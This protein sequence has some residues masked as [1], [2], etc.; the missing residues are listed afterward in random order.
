MDLKSDVFHF[1]EARNDTF[2]IK[3]P[4]ESPHFEKK[5]AFWPI[6][7][8]SRHSHLYFEPKSL[9]VRPKLSLQ[10]VIKVA[11]FTFLRCGTTPF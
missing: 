6:G 4:P 3:R 11:R 5:I 1:F 8:S 7:S 2:L 10:W 9:G